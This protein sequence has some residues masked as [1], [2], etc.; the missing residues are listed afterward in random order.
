MEYRTVERLCFGIQKLERV[1]I[2]SLTIS[3]N[4]QAVNSFC[5]SGQT[6][7]SGKLLIS[8]GNAARE[9]T[10]IDPITSTPVRAASLNLDRWYASQ[11]TL[12]DGR[13]LI[14][15]GGSPY[16]G[17][18]YPGQAT[19]NGVVSN[20]PEVYTD[21]QGWS[22][23][24]GAKSDDA[25]G[26]SGNRWWYPRQWVTPTGSVFGI[27][28]EKM[29]EMQ[30]NGVGSIR[31]IGNFKTAPNRFDN[32]NFPNTG[33]ASS[34]VMYDIGKIIQVG[35]NGYY[36]G[37]PTQSSKAATTFDINNIGTTGSVVVQETNPMANARQWP[38]TMVL[39]D[40]NVLVTGGSRFGEN[41]GADAVLAAET[42]NPNTGT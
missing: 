36:N 8:G 5:S 35:G 23:L 31:T 38:N 19:S 32:V 2:N 40:G 42:W 27:S 14:A 24:T 39:P 1:Q 33:P 29:W 17:G 18:I 10:I 21:G 12:P 37:Y 34:G 11:T 28:T 7:P 22:L 20:T 41:A 6:L 25:F 16:L 26:F 3:P 15:G 9:C 30:V 4:V 13:Q